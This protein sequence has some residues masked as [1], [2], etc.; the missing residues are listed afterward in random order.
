MA[1]SVP[2]VSRAQV[3]WLRLR[4]Q[5]LSPRPQQ[6]AVTVAHVVRHLG[7]VQAQDPAAA[8]LAI[9]ARSTGLVAADVQRAR[10]RERSVVRTWAMRST[11][12]LL[13][14]EDVGWLLALL[15]PLFVRTS[16]RRREALGLDEETCARAIRAL[17][18]ILGRRGPLTR[19]EIVEQLALRRIRLEGQARPH[20]IARAAL[21]GVVCL[22]PDRGAEPTYVLLEDWARPGRPLPPKEALAE[23][24]RR[25]LAAHG[26][27]G[28][29]DFAA[30][31]GLP[32]ADARTGLEA[33]ASELLEVEVDG[34]PAWL[35]ASRAPW[36]EE[37]PPPDPLVR[38]LPAFDPFLL[39]YRDRGFI[40]P[41]EH[42]RQIHPGGGVIRPALLLNGSVI[43][44]WRSQP[45]RGGRLV[46]VSPF[47]PLAAEVRAGLAGEAADV[48][49]FLGT[50]A[51]LRVAE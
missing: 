38:L 27:A 40:V 21:E 11:L 10:E 49:R 19:A 35:P 26:P 48:G 1:P 17:R 45:Q 50:P 36:F 46:E 41:A 2:S 43:G 5:R 14:A 31:T 12:H 24:A 44:T 28:L 29:E 15:G 9:R 51:I 6:P 20:L 7:A 16:Q 34:R 25:Y 30:W 13:A 37:P 39:G 33:I 8:P 22:G 42:S 32:R 18:E 4:A 23:L 3:R 47:V